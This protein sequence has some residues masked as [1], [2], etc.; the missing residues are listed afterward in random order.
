MVRGGTAPNGVS[1]VRVSRG[2]RP[3]AGPDASAGQDG[4][5]HRD[6]PAH[7][8][9]CRLAPG[10]DLGRRGDSGQSHRGQARCSDDPA[11][12]PV[13][14]DSAPARHLPVPKV[15]RSDLVADAR[16]LLLWCAAGLADVIAPPEIGVGAGAEPSRPLE[17]AQTPTRQGKDRTVA[18]ACARC[19]K[20]LALV[21]RMQGHALCARCTQAVHAERLAARAQYA[22]LLYSVGV[23]G[24]ASPQV[25]TEIEQV[26]ALAGFE[27]HEL[28][29]ANRSA[30]GSVAE[31]IL[32]D[33]LVTPDEEAR[34]AMLGYALGL[35]LAH[36]GPEI[37]ARY[38]IAQINAGRVP[39][40]GQ[41][42]IIL[43]KAEIAHLEMP[44]TLLKEVVD[45]QM[46]GGYSGVSFR[47]AKG[48][49][50]NTGGFRG[51]SVV[52]GSHMEVADRGSLTVTSAR[53]V[54]SGTR[55]TLEF[56]HAKLINLDVFTDG[57]RFHVSNRQTPSLF[58]LADGH[59]VAAVV[60]AACQ[61]LDG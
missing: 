8:H 29:T 13:F 59:V 50:F 33:D 53:A 34:L 41:P 19:G 14:R 18:E 38:L 3:S 1:D 51:R 37:G 6:I 5:C 57:V 26:R 45:R 35:S 52:V 32:A 21:D 58:Q 24:A 10:L 43:K 36:L 54:F 16:V 49:R 22:S 31:A 30:F 17:C 61:S 28:A 20:A 27:P 9:R 46:R 7:V 55:K 48:V 56:Q 39:V 15:R 23:S 44:A 40:V 42:G 25:W 4:L 12:R 60:N 2:Y 47:I 11:Y